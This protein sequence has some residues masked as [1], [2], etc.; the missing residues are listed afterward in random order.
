MALKELQT[1]LEEVFNVEASVQ[2]VARTLERA[3][4]TMKSV[5]RLLCDQQR[6]LQSSRIGHTSRSRAK[7]ARSC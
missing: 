4:Y 1:E 7:R 6:H 5:C 2:T 3:G